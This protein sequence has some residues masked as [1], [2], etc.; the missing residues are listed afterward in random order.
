MSF[1]FIKKDKEDFELYKGK[2]DQSINQ[3]VNLITF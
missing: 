3:S 1:I 2:S